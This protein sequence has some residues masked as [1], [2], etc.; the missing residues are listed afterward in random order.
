MDLGYGELIRLGTSGLARYMHLPI[1]LQGFGA[2]TEAPST[3]SACTH[4]SRKGL[5]LPTRVP[6]EI[7]KTSG[8]LRWT[9]VKESFCIDWKNTFRSEHLFQPK[10]LEGRTGT[11]IYGVFS[12]I[13]PCTRICALK[14]HA[15]DSQTAKADEP[16]NPGTRFLDSKN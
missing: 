14:K 6:Y 3:I 7:L 15:A 13:F 9:N 1:Y 16:Q 12:R 8:F 4:S 10:K 11:P 5:N 2:M